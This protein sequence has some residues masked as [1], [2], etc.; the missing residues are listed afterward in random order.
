MNQ[1]T[2]F[3]KLKLTFALLSKPIKNYFFIDSTR[4]RKNNN[5]V[6]IFIFLIKNIKKISCS[7]QLMIFTI[8][9]ELSIIFY[10]NK[11]IL[12]LKKIT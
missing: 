7:H 6:L 11:L 9:F 2:I 10:F 12:L 8:L 1:A 4:V 5:K 3:N